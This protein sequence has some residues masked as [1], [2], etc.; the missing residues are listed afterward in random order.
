MTRLG[1]RPVI[2]ALGAALA[3]GVL[4]RVALHAGG[5]IGLP[6]AGALGAGGRA[7]VALGAPWLVVAWALGAAARPRRVGALAGGIALGLGTVA[8]YA[9]T[10]AA[11]GARALPYAWPVAPAWALVA[12]AAGAL[13]GLAG[14]AWHTG[15]RLVRAVA[16][17]LPAG[18]LAG[19]ALL[20]AGEWSGRAAQ[21]VLALEL[22]VALA[23]VGVA[24]RRGPAVVPLALACA[25]AMALGEGAVRDALRLAGWEGP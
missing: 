6:Y 2:L 15:G 21:A 14:A 1:L 10:V 17:A 5:E 24:A 9:L 12:V 11:A 3:L 16:V 7:V 22:G 13:L 8:W 25:V 4:G 19:E 20:L 18:A 23:V